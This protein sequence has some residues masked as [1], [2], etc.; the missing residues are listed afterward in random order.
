[1]S[2]QPVSQTDEE[3][4]LAAYQR[5]CEADPNGAFGPVYPGIAGAVDNDPERAL[6]ACKALKKRGLLTGE[7]GRGRLA[8]LSTSLW[9]TEKGARSA[10]EAR[11]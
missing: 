3:R 7:I 1:M 10:E 5:E 11:R 2:A 4:V 6:V 8:I 9:T